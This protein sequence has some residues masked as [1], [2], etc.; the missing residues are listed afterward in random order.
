VGPPLPDNWQPATGNR[1]NFPMPTLENLLNIDLSSVSF[2]AACGFS[3]LGGVLSFLSPCVLP[4]IPAYVSFISGISVEELTGQGLGKSTARVAIAALLFV[5][6]LSTIF[7]IAG[8]ISGVLSGFVANYMKIIEKVAGV[9]IVLFGIYMLGFFKFGFME[10]ERRLKLSRPVNLIG[11]YILGLAFAF[12][13]TPCIGPIIAGIL[14]I[15]A[16]QGAVKGMILLLFYSL[17]LAIPFIISALALNAFFSV[18]KKIKKVFRIIEI[19]SGVLLI[20]A[21]VL[22]FFGILSQAV[23]LLQ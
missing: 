8:G 16:T 11:A 20:A 18:F 15:A 7:V 1:Y 12:G 5:L 14:L 2:W 4:L 3:F 9:L 23:S 10:T 17:G 13:W 21:G 6:G 19:V 22:V